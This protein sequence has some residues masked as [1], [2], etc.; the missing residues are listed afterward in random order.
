MRGRIDSIGRGSS[1]S[2]FSRI[3]T[4]AEGVASTLVWICVCGWAA[5]A[6]AQ[7]EPPGAAVA[8]LGA[9]TRAERAL[10]APHFE[11]GA[12]ILVEFSDDVALPGIVMGLPVRAA[13]ADL[14]ALLAEPTGYP[15]FMP[16]LDTVQPIDRRGS[17]LAYRWTWRTALFTLR[18]NALVTRWPPPGTRADRPHRVDVRAT[19]GDLGTGRLVWRV[20]PWGP[21]R[22]LLVLSAR[23]DV[24]GANWITRQIQ[25]GIRSVNRSFNIALGL[26][27][28]LSTRREA[29]Q[30]AGMRGLHAVVEEPLPEPR[31]PDV[32]VVAL[33][34][35]L[36][37]GDLILLELHG[38]RLAQ[39]SVIG[40]CWNEPGAVRAV[41]HDPRAFAPALIAGSWAH[42]LA[43]RDEVLD[44]AWGVRM[45]LLGTEGR[46]RVQRA[47]GLVEMHA[48]EGALRGGYWRFEQG[49]LPWGEAHLVG[50]TRFDPRTANWL[51]RMLVDGTPDFGLGIV[52]GA[53]VMVL[54]ALRTRAWEWHEERARARTS[55]PTP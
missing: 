21:E 6:R 47:P 14:A 33:A 25:D 30:R 34:P 1:F 3:P 40:R 43:E 4:G 7:Q 24:R 20:Y 35:T 42:V 23:L 2:A 36:A 12:V 22:S 46:L 19:G 53:Q 15:R 45:P 51:L 10:L 5:S 32:D 44:V 9:F 48:V 29:E 52:A 26:T 8:P 27:M 28:L 49:L 16:A 39:A 41:M 55:P 11:R 50:W 13:A 37:R 31:R 54:R 38:E 17:L 18:G